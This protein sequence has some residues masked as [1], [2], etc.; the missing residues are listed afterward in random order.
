MGDILLCKST[1]LVFSGAIRE[2]KTSAHGSV[3]HGARGQERQ[4]GR[5]GRRGGGG[6]SGE[7]EMDSQLRLRSLSRWLRSGCQQLVALPLP[8]PQERRRFV[9]EG[10]KGDGIGGGR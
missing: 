3:R 7:G 10:V 4:Q 6:G 1:N 5:R 9:C 8:V 2:Y